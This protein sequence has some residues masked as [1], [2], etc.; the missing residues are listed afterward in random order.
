MKLYMKLALASLAAVLPT[1]AGLYTTLLR[2]PPNTR[3][4]AGTIPMTET[5]AVGRL[6]AGVACIR[7]RGRRTPL[8]L[9]RPE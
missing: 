2:V 7:S 5:P 8:K 3:L 6:E 1:R 4:E 9:A